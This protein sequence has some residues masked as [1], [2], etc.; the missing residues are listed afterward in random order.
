MKN[1]QDRYISKSSFQITDII[2]N[3][4]WLE[5][6][7][8]SRANFY[9]D[10]LTKQQQKQDKTYSNHQTSIYAT[11]LLKTKQS[12][13]AS[14]VFVWPSQ[15]ARNRISRLKTSV[16]NAIK[17]FQLSSVFCSHH[18]RPHLIHSAKRK[19]GRDGLCLFCRNGFAHFNLFIM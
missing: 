14:N 1:S 15:H 9:Y 13:L 8:F 11:K 5:W 6:Y 17:I 12:A 4:K 2:L 10:G 3:I 16:P 7:L 19:M 18:E